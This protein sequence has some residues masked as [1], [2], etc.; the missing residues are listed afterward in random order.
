MLDSSRNWRDDGPDA[1]I[2]AT[3]TTRWSSPGSWSAAAFDIDSAC[4]DA[5]L[6][7]EVADAGHADARVA[8]IVVVAE[9]RNRAGLH[10]SIDDH[11]GAA[12]HDHPKLADSNSRLDVQLLPDRDSRKIEPQAADAELVLLAHVIGGRGCIH[13]IADAVAQRDVE[14]GE[15]DYDGDESD[16]D[17]ERRDPCSGD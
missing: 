8:S 5:R 17:D 9:H 4:T 3:I 10:T 2:G 1:P 11:R 14:P 13:A 7:K 16:Q 15:S 6:E 12:W